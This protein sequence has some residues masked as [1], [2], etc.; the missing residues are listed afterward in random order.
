MIIAKMDKVTM[1]YD[2]YQFYVNF[3]KEFQLK[4]RKNVA[5]RMMYHASSTKGMGICCFAA[6]CLTCCC[7]KLGG[8]CLTVVDL[9]THW[10][11]ALS[12]Y[13]NCDVA[14][15]D[16]EFAKAMEAL[17]KIR[18]QYVDQKNLKYKEMDYL[19]RNGRTLQYNVTKLEEVALSCMVA[20][21]AWFNDVMKHLYDYMQG[22][23]TLQ[24]KYVT[25]EEK[26]ARA[27]VAVLPMFYPA[28]NRN[29]RFYA[30]MD[31][32]VLTRVR[33]LTAM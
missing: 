19:M 14:R 3:W 18:S 22:L 29:G 6:S 26:D 1:V 15:L 32:H 31:Q 17:A 11:N 5:K 10:K 4:H 9:G 7:C 27:I 28:F 30:P 2:E 8:R 20:G 33:L 23:A 24:M 12:I 25:I 21:D 16:A 13:K